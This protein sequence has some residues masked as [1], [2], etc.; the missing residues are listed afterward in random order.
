MMKELWSMINSSGLGLYVIGLASLAGMSIL[1]GLPRVD[2]P[3]TGVLTQYENLMETWAT[4]AVVGQ[5]IIQPDKA[6]S[7]APWTVHLRQSD[8]A[9]RKQD[10]KAAQKA[11]HQAYLATLGSTTWEGRLDVGDASLRIGEVAKGRELVKARSLYM[12]ALLR[13]RSQGSLDGVLRAGEAFAA[14]GDLEVAN[15]AIRIAEGLAA[16]GNDPYAPTR[17]RSVS[18]RLTTRFVAEKTALSN[19]F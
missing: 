11:W 17:V 10:V 2:Q 16:E 18:E 8:E 3:V 1:G 19:P 5:P 6:S 9:L 14:L 15:Q 12:E 4:E 13:A 7:D